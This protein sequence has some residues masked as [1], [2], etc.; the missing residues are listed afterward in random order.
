MKIRKI[1]VVIIGCFISILCTSCT[2]I[3]TDDTAKKAHIVISDSLME[4]DTDVSAGD[5]DIKVYTLSDSDYKEKDVATKSSITAGYQKIQSKGKV[6]T[7]N[8]GVAVIGD[9]AYE[10]YN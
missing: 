2:R 9:T 5:K 3:G 1:A 10:Q 6:K 8:S 7:Y 4:S